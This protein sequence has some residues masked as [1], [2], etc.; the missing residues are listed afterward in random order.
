MPYGLKDWF[1]SFIQICN[2]PEPIRIRIKLYKKTVP[3]LQ[4]PDSDISTV[5]KPNPDLD[6]TCEL[7]NS[8]FS[9]SMCIIRNF[10]KKDLKSFV[11]ERFQFIGERVNR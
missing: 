3:T 5:R 2:F 8:L 11:N 7:Y 10:I 6:P 1:T 4:K 9:L